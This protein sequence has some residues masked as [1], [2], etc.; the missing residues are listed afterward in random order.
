MQVE[1]SAMLVACDGNVAKADVA[2]KRARE[3]CWNS[4]VQPFTVRRPWP[5]SLG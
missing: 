3:L 4:A 1:R 2:F 5:S